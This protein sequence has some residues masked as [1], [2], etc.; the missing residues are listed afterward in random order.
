MLCIIQVVTIPNS[1]MYLVKKL[2]IEQKE[3]KL[4][5]RIL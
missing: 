2:N 4:D 1:V 5:W 3:K